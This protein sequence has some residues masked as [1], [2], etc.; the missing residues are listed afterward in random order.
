MNDFPVELFFIVIYN[1]LIVKQYLAEKGFYKKVIAIYYNKKKGG[2][3]VPL[4]KIL[5]VLSELCGVFFYFINVNFFV[6]VKLPD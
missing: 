5:R 4:A 2:Q 6:A 3:N 1:S